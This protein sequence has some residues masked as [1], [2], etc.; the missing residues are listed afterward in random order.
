M[1]KHELDNH[2]QLKLYHRE[3]ESSETVIYVTQPVS[4][5]LTQRDDP[6]SR[7]ELTTFKAACLAKFTLLLRNLE[8]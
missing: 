7:T 5:A 1:S 4:R 6:A 8:K 2:S 3:N